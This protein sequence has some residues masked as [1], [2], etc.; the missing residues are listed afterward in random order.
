MWLQLRVASG[1][2]R[3]G[4]HFRMPLAATAS[5][6]RDSVVCKTRGECPPGHQRT[7]ARARVQLRARR[8]SGVFVYIKHT[9]TLAGAGESPSSLCSSAP[10]TPE[11]ARARGNSRRLVLRTASEAH[12]RAHACFLGGSR[13][14]TSAAVHVQARSAA[15]LEGSRRATRRTEKVRRFP[16]GHA[17]VKGLSWDE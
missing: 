16:G 4:C 1:L 14:L 2:G 5:A 6:C 15:S 17:R 9:C 10:K 11:A 13:F 7:R 12:K 3:R 8:S